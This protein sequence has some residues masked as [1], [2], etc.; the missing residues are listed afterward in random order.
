MIEVLEK[1]KSRGRLLGVIVQ[2]GGQTPLKL[3]HALRR[4][5]YPILGTTVDSLDLA[6]DRERFR[7]L[8]IR[9]GLRQPA[10]DI[11]RSVEDARRIAEDIGYPLMLRPSYVLGGRAMEIVRDRAQLERYVTEAVQVS[12][13]SP[14]LLDAY[15][16]EAIEVDVDALSDGRKV[17]VA[18]VMEHIEE[19]GIHSGD[20]GCVLPP[21]SLPAEV[22][23]EIERQT[24]VMAEALKVVGCMNVQFAVRREG[25]DWKIYVLEVNPR[26]SRTIPF[27]SKAR[28]MP[29]AKVAVRLMIGEAL[30]SFGLS[31]VQPTHVSVK[32]AVFPFA[33]FPGADPLLG[34]EMRSTGEVM[35]IDVDFAG[36]FYKSQV[37][38]GVQLPRAGTVFLSMRES[39]K[40][41]AAE[42]AGLYHALGFEL[43]A[44]AGT[45]AVIAAAG[46]PVRGIN[47]V[48]EGRPD[49]T[50]ALRNG[51][52][53]LV[54]NTAGG[55]Q[56]TQ[57]GYAIR[58]TAL[59]MRIPVYTTVAGA[60]AAAAA[61]GV[62]RRPVQVRAL[63]DYHTAGAR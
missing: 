27:V 24:V 32:E 45:A 26:A 35:G 14:L 43:C 23:T 56:S 7:D 21:Y 15:L 57:D 54:V 50:D 40:S 8:L 60:R 22:I 29:L 25:G 61:I 33:K 62:A 34:P 48:S 11:A 44:T 63:G 41:A 51:V 12:G 47:K 42:L 52:I 17:Y 53:H 39:D 59:E 9:L 49:I 20:S 55:A 16:S 5:G 13:D 58:R 19:A 4:A 37:A 6:E 3:A 31:D 18:G 36:A 1:E 2:L 38:A 46:L 10:G 28:G 30:A